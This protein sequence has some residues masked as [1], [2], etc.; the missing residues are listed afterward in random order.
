MKAL[1]ARPA[2]PVDPQDACHL[3][4]RAVGD[5]DLAGLLAVLPVPQDQQTNRMIHA[6]NTEADG[7]R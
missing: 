4:P 6:C 5:Q 3:P 7:Y 1:R 2:M